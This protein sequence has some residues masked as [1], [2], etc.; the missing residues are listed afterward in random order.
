MQDNTIVK[1]QWPLQITDAVGCFT[2]ILSTRGTPPEGELRELIIREGPF[3]DWY[4]TTGAAYR[5]RMLNAILPMPVE[6]YRIGGDEYL[7]TLAPVF[8]NIRNSPSALATYRCHTGNY[9]HGTPLDM[10][11]ARAY[12]QRW[13]ASA[14]M[15][16]R[17]LE[18]QGVQAEPIVWKLRNFN[19]LWLHRLLLAQ[20]DIESLVPPGHDF[21]F[22]DDADSGNALHVPQR[23]KIPFIEL[24]G[25]YWG[26]P[27]NCETA[28]SELERL[29]S[30][31]AK[32][33]VFW[34]TSFW[35]LDHYTTFYI[36]LCTR[37]DRCLVND[38]LIAFDLRAQ[39][40]ERIG[41]F[42]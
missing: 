15:L 32:Y 2:G 22:V 12:L 3:Y 31:G 35:W 23:R 5:R 21:I 42:P 41:V 6:S 7:I 13:E 30:R 9:Y 4:F 36:Y 29:R 37:F 26:P 33:I 17:H 11:R 28:I 16:Q 38:R 18:K 24:E 34:W 20:S 10:L 14:A 40:S 27:P 39:I 1:V 19:Y 8:G 25:E